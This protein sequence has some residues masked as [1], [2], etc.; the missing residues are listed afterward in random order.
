MVAFG[1]LILARP[2]QDLMTLA[3]HITALGLLL[4]V[5][6]LIAPPTPLVSVLH[7]E[8]IIRQRGRLE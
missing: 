1:V 2:P 6:H 8:R 7:R 5:L 4:G 3:A